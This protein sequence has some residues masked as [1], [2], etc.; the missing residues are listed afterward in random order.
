MSPEARYVPWLVVNSQ[1]MEGTTATVPPLSC[2][3]RHGS[4]SGG[5]GTD[6]ELPEKAMST[7]DLLL[8]DR[9]FLLTSPARRRLCCAC[10]SGWS[11]DSF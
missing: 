2:A 7:P 10:C 3:V 9:V 4:L 6:S 5:P 8:D 11:S 1:D